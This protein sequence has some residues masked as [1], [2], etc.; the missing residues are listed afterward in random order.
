M[1]RSIIVVI[2]LIGVGAGGY[3]GYSQ[4]ASSPGPS[5]ESAPVAL[6][7]EVA[8]VTAEA[9][10]EPAESAELR[11]EVPGTVAELLVAEGDEVQAGQPLARLDTRDLELRVASAEA[12][13]AQAQAAYDELVEGAT[14]EEVAVA[15]TQLQQ[16]QG[17]LS[18]IEGA[19]TASDIAAAQSDL[20]QA[21]TALAELEAGPE[22][23]EIAAAQA[24]LDAARAEHERLVTQIQQ[25][26]DNASRAKTD[27]EHALEQATLALQQAQ[28]DYSLAYWNYHGVQ[29]NGRAPSTN[30]GQSS[31]ELSDYGNLSAQEAFRQAEIALATAELALAQAQ[32]AL[33]NAR[34]NEITLVAQA[35]QNAARAEADAREARAALDELL[36][37]AEPEELARARAAVALAQANLEKLSGQQRSGSLETAGASL[38]NA[39]ARLADLTAEARA[40]DLVSAKARI[41]AAEVS[42]RQAQVALDKATLY[43]PISGSVVELNL[44]LGELPGEAE[45]ALVVADLSRWEIETDDLTELDIVKVREQAPVTISFDS[46]PG[47]ELPGLVSRIEGI[48]KNKEGDITYAVTVAPQEWDARLRW[49]MTATVMI[50]P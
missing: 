39:Q 35:E 43:A 46:L 44:E 21:R 9:V 15:E 49:K 41:Q 8:L 25:T 11:F 22:A 50:E 7:Q 4:L 42:L 34:Q 33:E 30:E 23:N 13:L 5:S 14:P 37:G 6:A 27:A 40:T 32:T 18:Q 17:Q 38:A 12:Q 2:T 48:G 26:R 24:R 20:A 3:L 1:L 19:V 28:S 31:P 10:V 45:P 47:L 16:A 36:D 29:Q